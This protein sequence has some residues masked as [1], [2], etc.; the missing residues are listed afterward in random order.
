[1][2]IPTFLDS[3]TKSRLRETTTTRLEKEVGKITLD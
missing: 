2:Q 1:M 3:E